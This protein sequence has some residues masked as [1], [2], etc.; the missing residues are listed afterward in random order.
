MADTALQESPTLFRNTFVLAADI[1]PKEMI[2]WP[3]YNS[4]PKSCKIRQALT[5][6]SA[7]SASSES[8]DDLVPP[9]TNPHQPVPPGTN[10]HRLALGQPLERYIRKHTSD[11]LISL[12]K[13]QIISLIIDITRPLSLPLYMGS[14]KP[15]YLVHILLVFLY[16]PLCW[17]M[18]HCSGDSSPPCS[19]SKLAIS[20][21]LWSWLQVSQACR[22]M[23]RIKALL[24]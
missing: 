6:S 19:L 4:Q 16:T 1:T 10:S 23:S 12:S 14:N 9:S 3:D 11:S 8:I 15:F 24:F 2:P 17:A 5:I 22:Q 20:Q 18:S 21:L 7:W 13:G